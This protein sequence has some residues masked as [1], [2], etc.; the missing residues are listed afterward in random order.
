MLRYIW[1]GI[2]VLGIALGLVVGLV[3]GGVFFF[4][5]LF[6]F[7]GLVIGLAIQYLRVRH[8]I[9]AHHAHTPGTRMEDRYGK[10]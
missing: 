10:P 8:E 2:F 1:V 5:S 7:L 4:L 3:F 9:R 6:A